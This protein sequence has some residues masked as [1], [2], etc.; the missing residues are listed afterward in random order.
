MGEPYLLW[1]EVRWGLFSP[2]HKSGVP[3]ARP[4]KSET[5]R[6]AWVRANPLMR[7]AIGKRH[8]TVKAFRR[9]HE[10]K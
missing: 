3:E 9:K 1:P 5:E 2:P 8:V 6:D 4:F 7:A 10:G